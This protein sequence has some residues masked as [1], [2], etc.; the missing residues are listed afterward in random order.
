M[1]RLISENPYTPTGW[2]SRHNQGGG[3]VAFELASIRRTSE[4]CV[5][6]ESY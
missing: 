6:M 3:G 4:F 1:S 2:H 5:C